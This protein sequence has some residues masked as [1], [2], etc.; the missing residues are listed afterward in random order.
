MDRKKEKKPETLKKT[1]DRVLREARLVSDYDTDFM[2]ILR[3][4]RLPLKQIAKLSGYSQQTVKRYTSTADRCP[5][6]TEINL[7][8]ILRQIIIK[9][10]I[11]AYR[12]NGNNKREYALTIEKYLRALQML[13][14][15]KQDIPI[16]DDI[17]SLERTMR[18]EDIPQ[19]VLDVLQR[20]YDA[21]Q[22][23]LK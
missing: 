3:S 13:E 9:T 10:A 6:G 5:Q 22:E 14:D 8:Y 12:D 19:D 20:R 7:S 16:R 15:M 18:E 21:L 2:Q 1:S 17:L 23:K 4:Q 11:D